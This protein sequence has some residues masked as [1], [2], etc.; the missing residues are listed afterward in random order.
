MPAIVLLGAQWGDEG[1]GKATDLLGSSVDYVVKYNGGNNAGHTIVIGD[2]KYALHLLPSGILTPGV[3]PVIGNGVVIDLAVLFT[4]IDDLEAR[5]VDTS[6]LLVSA[7]AHLIGQHHRMIDKVAERF[8]GKRQARHHRTGHRADVRRQD[9]PGRRA[10][11][12]PVRREDPAAEGRGRPRAEEPPAR[13]GLQP[14]RHHRRRGGRG[15]PRRTPSGCARWSRTRRWC[16]GRPS[17]RG[18]TVLLEGGQA[19][20]LDVDHGTYPF[21]T[22]SNPTA[23]GAC[24]GSG[25]PPTRIDRVIAVVKA[26]ATRVGSGP[27]PTELHDADGER[28][29]TDG[30][31]FGTTTGRPRRCGWYDAVVARYAARVNGVTDFVLTKLDVLTGWERIPVCVAYEVDGVR[32]DEMPMTQTDFH[33]AKPVY[34]HLDGWDEDIT[35]ARSLADLP[36]TAQAYVQALEDMSGA[37]ISAI[38]VGPGRDQT[39]EIRSL[40]G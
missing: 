10:G 33:H 13:Q 9:V 1:K 5:G 35:G 15:V 26:Y 6:R 25:I 11:A 4:E 37:P 36:K 17:T 27:F 40:L 24:T 8:L 19:T 29:R 28:L 23:G 31:E 38:G 30:A 16:S 7:S 12:G 14:P 20:L 21:V 18:K 22:S 2:E 39:V 32:H 34:E 3:T